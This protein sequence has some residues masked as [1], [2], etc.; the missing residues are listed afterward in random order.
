MKKDRLFSRTPHLL[1][2]LLAGVVFSGQAFSESPELTMMKEQIR[3]L[4]QAGAQV[5]QSMYDM[6]NQLE[7]MEA[8]EGKTGGESAD[9]SCSQNISGTWKSSGGDQTVVLNPNGTGDFVQRTVGG[10]AYTSRVK[11]NWSATAKNITFNYTSDLEYTQQET[12]EVTFKSRPASGTVSCSF[13][14]SVLNIGGVPYYR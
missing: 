11:Y 12:G 4:E 7:E 1:V 2:L 5:P 9:L 8:K 3:Q 13:A 14:G 6:V 10:E